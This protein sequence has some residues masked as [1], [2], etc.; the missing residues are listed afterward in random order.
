M[1]NLLCKMDLNCFSNCYVTARNL[2]K[3]SLECLD[4]A[5]V[6]EQVE[7]QHPLCGPNDESLFCDVVLLGQK[8]TPARV[9]VIISATHG[10]EGFTGSAI[11]SDCLTLL[12]NILLQQNDLGVVMIHALNPWG[13]A[14]LRRCDH[15][16]IDLNRNFIDFTQVLP[17]NPEYDSLLP[18]LTDTQWLK[19]S[20]LSV[21]S[22][23]TDD[24][25]H[26]IEQLTAGQYSDE[27]GL[28]YGGSH[29]SWSRQIVEK[30]SMNSFIFNAELISVIDIH[31]GLGPYGYGEVINDHQPHTR[32]FEWVNTWYGNNA[33]SALLGESCSAPK[34]GLL[35][36]YWHDLIQ[37][38]G[39]F[40]TLEN[41]TYSVTRLITALLR[42]QVFHNSLK[43]GQNRDLTSPHILNLKTFFYPYEESWKQQ[44]I[45]RARQVISMALTGITK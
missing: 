34:H 33:C 28:F 15:E 12:N 5:L 35:D 11:Q 22:P 31:T 9:L 21:L 39:C 29:P 19:Q 10:I 4:T 37:D 1:L 7:Y 18:V 23:K 8:K 24:F 40:I 14:W 36:Y 20:N 13:F 30:I 2:F 26:L 43:T 27:N 41:G 32:G 45:F 6:L 25:N 16:G 3:K 42:E 17:S 38:R 44:V